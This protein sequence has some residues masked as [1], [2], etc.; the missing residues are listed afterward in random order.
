MMEYPVDVIE[1]LVAQII[2]EPCIVWNPL[3]RLEAFEFKE[4]K[5]EGKV[6]S[7]HHFNRSLDHLTT[8][9]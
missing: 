2:E 7:S 5:S 1:V 8:R 3:E 4:Q 6:G 9:V